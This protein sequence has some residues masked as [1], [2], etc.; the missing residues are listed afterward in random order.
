MLEPA[1]FFLLIV[2]AALSFL[3]D[4][5]CT[6]PD[7]RFYSDV[8]ARSSGV[9]VGAVFRSSGTSLISTVVDIGWFGLGSQVLISVF[10]GQ[11]RSCLHRAGAPRESRAVRDSFASL[12]KQWN[13]RSFSVLA[14]R[15]YTTPPTPS[16]F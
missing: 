7:L 14:Y 2:N 13:L 8:A 16:K 15:P 4:S 10:T 9:G 1:V 5:L 11:R 12:P 6:S 3:L